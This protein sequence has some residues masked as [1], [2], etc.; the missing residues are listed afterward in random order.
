MYCFV[1]TTRDNLLL[2]VVISRAIISSANSWSGG[3]ETVA[4]DDV[5]PGVK[6]VYNIIQ[7]HVYTYMYM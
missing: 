5:T 4:D 7:F 3:S 6:R 1:S 2:K